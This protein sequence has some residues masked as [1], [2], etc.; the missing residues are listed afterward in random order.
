MP[1]AARA[2][3]IDWTA[4]FSLL[5]TM[6]DRNILP[7]AV[8]FDLSIFNLGRLVTPLAWGWIVSKW[9]YEWTY[10][11][12]A[13]LMTINFAIVATYRPII[14]TT[15]SKGHA[16]WSEVTEITGV[17]R[18][19][20]ILGGNLVYTVMNAFVMGGFIYLLTPISAQVFGVG[21]VEFSRLFAMIALGAFIAGLGLGFSGGVKRAGLALIATNFMAAGFTVAFAFS[22]TLNLGYAFAFLFGFVNAVHV[23][24]G[25]IALQMSITENVRGRLAGVYELAWAGFPA[26]GFFFPAIA[27]F[28]GPTSALAFGGLFLVFINSSV[29]V[30]NPT[31]RRLKMRV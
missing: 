4:R 9:G 12:I 3:A 16:I 5:P 23:G 14:A 27:G 15:S 18:R 24:L 8:S 2:L 7:R 1:S 11:V 28:L 26:G 31:L 22:P 29:A 17:V 10:F 6:V 20:P 25:N 13:T 30:L 21:P 19:N